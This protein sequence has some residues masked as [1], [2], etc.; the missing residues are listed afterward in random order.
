M[1]KQ[2]VKDVGTIVRITTHTVRNAITHQD[3][4]M[5]KQQS[6]DINAEDA[7]ALFTADTITA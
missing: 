5:G 1:R 6:E 7:E 3:N 4:R 2:F